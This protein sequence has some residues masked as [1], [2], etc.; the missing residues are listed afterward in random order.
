MNSHDAASFAAE[1][2]EYDGRNSA[3]PPGCDAA[4]H[5]GVTFGH[6]RDAE[7]HVREQVAVSARIVPSVAE[8]SIVMPDLP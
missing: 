5:A 2:F 3:L 7:L 1:L 8:L 6:R 4:G